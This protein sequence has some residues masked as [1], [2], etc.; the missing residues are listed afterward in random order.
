MNTRAKRTTSFKKKYKKEIVAYTLIGLPLLWWTV[1]FVIAL[2]WA[3]GTSFTNMRGGYGWDFVTRIGLDNYKNIFT[4][5]TSQF[6]A[7]WSSMKVTLIWTVVMMI[8]NNLM[9]L[10]CAFLI[11]SLKKGGKVFLALLFWPSLVSAVVG[12]DLS[13]TIFSSESSGVINQIIM[14]FGGKPVAWFEQEGTAMFALMVIPFFFGFSQKMLI[15]YASIVSIPPS[16]VE[17]ASLE[18][19]SKFKIFLTVTLPLM[20]NSIVLNTLLSVIDGFKVLGPMQLVTEGGPGTSTQSVMLL[21]YNSIFKAPSRVGQGCAYAFV[22]FLFII[23]V[24][25]IQKKIAGKEETTIE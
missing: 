9:G 23:V 14:F 24:S 19:S 11:K 15:Y 6:K 20:K 4:A 3:F 17:A 2:F 22:L 18:T 1:F 12:A 16:Y 21:I 5:G 8:G 7:F 13:K 25:I 10:L